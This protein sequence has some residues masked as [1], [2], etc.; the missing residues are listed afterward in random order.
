MKIIIEHRDDW[1]L[2]VRAARAAIESG[3]E[4]GGLTGIGF[5]NGSYYGVKRNKDSVRVYP[6]DNTSASEAA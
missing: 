1:L 2:Q 6:Q 4:V 3:L 5:E